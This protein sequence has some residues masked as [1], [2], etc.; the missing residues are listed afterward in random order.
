[1]Y[2]SIILTESVAG[3]DNCFIQRRFKLKPIANCKI[4]EASFKAVGW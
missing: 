3:M 1:M 2:N 4:N